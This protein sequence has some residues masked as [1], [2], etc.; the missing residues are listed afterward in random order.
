MKESAVEKILKVA[1]MLKE[2]MWGIRGRE[3]G[4]FI[5]IGFIGCELIYG[6]PPRP[7]GASLWRSRS[8]A[9]AAYGIL[10]QDGNFAQGHFPD[11]ASDAEAETLESRFLLKFT[12]LLFY[13][14]L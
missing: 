2:E 5:S 4:E 12:L 11:K 10:A 3:T 9:E 6:A 7:P 1:A 13:C 14:V 8:D